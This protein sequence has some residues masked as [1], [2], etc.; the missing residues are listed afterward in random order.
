MLPAV[1][2]ALHFNPE[3]R[4][5]METSVKNTLKYITKEVLE[6]QTLITL[7]C[8]V[9]LTNDLF[10]NITTFLL[11]NPQLCSKKLVRPREC[12]YLISAQD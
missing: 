11:L 12:R 4:K 8:R 7:P 1:L 5:K 9:F 10:D 3:T 6:K 2:D